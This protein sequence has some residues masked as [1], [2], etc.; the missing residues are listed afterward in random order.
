[1]GAGKITDIG[2]AEAFEKLWE[3]CDERECRECLFD[4]PSGECGICGGEGPCFQEKT[5]YRRKAWER[6][7]RKARK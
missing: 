5:I 1:M 3:Y 7:C 2:A 6:G 4:T